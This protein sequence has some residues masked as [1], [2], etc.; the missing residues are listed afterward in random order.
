MWASLEVSIFSTNGGEECADYLDQQLQLPRSNQQRYD[1]VAPSSS[2]LP[3]SSRVLAFA[4]PL[5]SSK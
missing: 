5:C 3:F 2:C 4:L 1:L